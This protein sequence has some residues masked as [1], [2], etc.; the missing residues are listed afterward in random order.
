MKLSTRRKFSLL[1]LLTIP[2]DIFAATAG[3]P[4]TKDGECSRGL[5]LQK[6]SGVLRDLV[7][8]SHQTLK[9]LN[10]RDVETM[11]PEQLAE[12]M[13]LASGSVDDWCRS[14]ARG[15]ARL[16][17]TLMKA[18]YGDF[19]NFKEMTG[20]IPDEDEEGN[21]ISECHRATY[22]YDTMIANLVDLGKWYKE[23]DVPP[24]PKKGQSSQPIAS[25]PEA[26][27]KE[28]ATDTAEDPDA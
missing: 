7:D 15:S 12:K 25:D 17:M 10:F 21:K 6:A 16:A 1:N 2:F 3:F 8:T 13:W 28:T 19:V 5:C 20:T 9:R 14:A 4:F 22:G 24:S 23:R 11:S 26:A 27:A 18:H